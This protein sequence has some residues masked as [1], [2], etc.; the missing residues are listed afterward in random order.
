MIKCV[1]HDTILMLIAED[2][3]NLDAVEESLSERQ[4]ETEIHSIL[5]NE[6]VNTAS[7]FEKLRF[8]PKRKSKINIPLCMMVSLPVVR[9]FLKNDVMNLASHFVSCGYMEGNG[10]F[11]VAIENDEG[12]TME[13]TSAIMSTWSEN[14][15]KSNNEFEYFLKADADLRG[16]SNKIFFV[17]DG[18]HRLQVWLP[19]I[20][21]DH[22]DDFE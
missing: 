20:N 14:W 8:H 3:E 12:K 2:M 4:L 19:I 17:W 22:A 18:N 13:V 15:M 6:T 5:K 16:F 11:Y 9:L 21:K 1:N 10:V 7:R